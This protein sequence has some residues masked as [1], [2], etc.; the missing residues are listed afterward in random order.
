MDVWVAHFVG[1]ILAKEDSV[2]ESVVASEEVPVS[3]R[4]HLKHHFMAHL[5]HWRIGR[6]WLRRWP[7]RYR[8]IY[9]KNIYHARVCPHWTLPSHDH[10]HITWT[11]NVADDR[12]SF[13]S[14]ES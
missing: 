3:W 11:K 13:L 6:W 2:R 9:T 4:D 7:I 8:T 5:H 14:E 1:A 10:A 12:Y